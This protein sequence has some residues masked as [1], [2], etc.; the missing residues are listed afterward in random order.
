MKCS[1]VAAA[2]VPADVAPHAGAWIEMSA[3]VHRPNGLLVAPHAGAWI[4]MRVGMYVVS[5][6][7][8]APHAGAWIEIRPPPR[9][10]SDCPVAPHAGAWIEMALQF[11]HARRSGSR[12]TR[13]RGLKCAL[14]PDVQRRS[15][16]AP[17]AGAW[18]EMK[19]SRMFFLRRRRA[20]RGR[21]D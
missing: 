21:V 14:L 18:I 3:P 12:P 16:V 5:Q 4:E 13:A 15:Q 7:L 9:L 20:P 6:P 17:H 19:I 8:V 11:V 2:D 10:S 1:Q